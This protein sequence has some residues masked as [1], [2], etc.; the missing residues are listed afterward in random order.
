MTISLNWLRQYINLP[1]S[2]ETIGNL[3]TSCGL[4]VEHLEKIESV[5][6]NLAGIVIGEVLTKEKHPDADRLSLTTVD[7]GNGII[8]PIVCG[9]VNVA[10]GQKVVVAT[11]GAMLYP[12]AGEPFVIKKAKIRGYASEGMICAEDEIG[13]GTSHEGIMV[14]D[15]DLPNG[16]P[17]NEFFKTET[18]FVFEI[19]LTPNRADAA[20][21]LGVVR[22]LKALLQRNYTLPSIENFKIDHTH[23][24]IAVTIQETGA[25]PRYSGITITG[26]TIRESP[27]WLKNRLKNIGISSINNVV[28]VTN[29]VL[30]E[31]GQ[32]LHAFDADKITRRAIV[33]KYGSAGEK[34]TTLD[35]QERTLQASNLM[36]CDA[37]KTEA[38]AGVMGGLASSVSWE[39][40]NI[41]I[42]SAYFS[43]EVVRKSSLS[44]GLKTDASFRYERGTDPNMTV[45]ALKRAALLILETAGGEI[46]SEIVD[47]YPEPI[48]DFPVTV[49]YKNID[50]LIGKKLEKNLIKRILSDL[51][52]RVL[53]ESETE[54][55]VLVPPYRVDVQREADIIEEILRIYGF[56]NVELTENLSASYLAAFPEKDKE[57]VQFAVTQ[58]LAGSG[59]QEIMTNSLT[60]QAYTEKFPFLR[61]GE[62]VEILNKLSEELGVMRQ[63]M[64]FSGLEVV[65]YN[66]NRRQKDLKLFEFGK[67]YHKNLSETKKYTEKTHLA[68]FGTGNKNAEIWSEKSKNTDFH[69]L[70][71]AVEKVFQHLKIKN[72]QS[73]PLDEEAFCYGLSYIHKNTEIAKVGLVNPA[74]TK[75]VGCKQAVFYADL[76]WEN[77]FKLYTTH[78]TYA[79]IPKFPEV[80]RDLSL[81]LDKNI[82]FA[83]IESLA[84]KTERNLLRY[85]NVFDVYE[86]ENLGAG[87]KSYSVSFMLQDEE[88]TLTD[89][90]IDKTME[91]LMQGFEKELGA[92]VRK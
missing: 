51:E 5:K 43:P 33:V 79:E 67:S 42:E 73:K 25:C 82:N 8:A 23:F 22:D 1:E 62:D 80:R 53:D 69:D 64:L 57:K 84:L 78:I 12:T 10:A 68:I 16:T 21:H 19:G 75:F 44:L 89:A 76:L 29:F 74:I 71:T 30:H 60:K 92:I 66:S 13:L 18:D 70:K 90:V 26:I 52:I 35:K 40:K 91:K 61:Q 38:V 27:D 28:D 41:F 65:V 3:L 4:E 49:L 36:I 88:K 81:V 6:G 54:I 63:S 20:S 46:A 37:E 7:I 47:V 85:I 48:Q 50:R 39:T 58:M 59:Y 56:N 45:F 87:K 77:L 83:A 32:P 17:A 31:L 55:R 86:G 34:F 72:I 2:A 9:A 14:L 15:T 11:L 24:P